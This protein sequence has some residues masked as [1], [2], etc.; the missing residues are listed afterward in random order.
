MG[1]ERVKVTCE[2][3]QGD[4]VLEVKLPAVVSCDLRMFPAAR[5][6]KLSDVMRS[7]KH[8]IKRVM[9]K[10]G[11][12]VAS[13]SNQADEVTYEKAPK[14]ERAKKMVKSVDEL[15]SHLKSQG[16]LP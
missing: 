12:P 13:G 7:R 15:I 2:T 6:A 11:T 8:P 5:A 1:E 9:F 16:L 4:Q 10:D 3:D 14:K